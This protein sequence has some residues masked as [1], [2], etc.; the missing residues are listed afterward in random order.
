[1]KITYLIRSLIILLFTFTCSDKPLTEPVDCAGTIGGNAYFDSCGICDANT[2]NDNIT[3]MDCSGQVADGS[4]ETVY[5]YDECNVCNNYLS[6]G[7]IKPSYPYFSSGPCAK[8]PGWSLNNLKNGAFSR[9]HRSETVS[10]THL[11]LP[12]IYSV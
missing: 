6:N 11:T 2:N 9:S 5:S 12:T 4:A 3:C 1:M 10:Y 8:P 7:G